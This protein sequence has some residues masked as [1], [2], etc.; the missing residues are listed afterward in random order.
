MEINEKDLENM[1]FDDL[2][3][4]GD[5]LRSRGFMTNLT[6]DY[7]VI[8][9]RWFRQVNFGGY[10]IA[11]IVGYSRIPGIVLVDVVELKNR[12]IKSEDFDQVLR[13]K[14]AIRQMIYGKKGRR[15]CIRMYINTYLVGPGMD[16]GHY[17]HNQLDT[18]VFTF[19]FTISGFEFESHN[20]SWYRPD[21]KLSVR[22]LSFADSCIVESDNSEENA[23]EVHRH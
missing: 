6:N 18:V 23:E 4:G 16:S 7:R 10:G 20:G 14:E 11:D 21:T 9:A 13:Y 15:S 19:K 1:I 2:K 12:P 22:A 17:I 3:E 8:T 5:R